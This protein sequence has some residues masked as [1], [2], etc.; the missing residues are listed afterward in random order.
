MKDELNCTTQIVGRLDAA[1]LENWKFRAQIS[2]IKDEYL[3]E[4]CDAIS[5]Q[6]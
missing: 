1:Y 3:H 4:S 6:Q 5:L 2:T